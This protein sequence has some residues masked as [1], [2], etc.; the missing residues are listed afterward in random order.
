MR[1]APVSPARRTAC[2]L[3]ADVESTKVPPTRASRTASMPLTGDVRIAPLAP[4]RAPASL[5][6]MA[7]SRQRR[8]AAGAAHSRLLRRSAADRCCRLGLAFHSPQ[9][10]G[11]RCRSSD[12]SPP[13]PL[14]R[15]SATGR[16]L[17]RNAATPRRLRADHVRGQSRRTL[18]SSSHA[19]RRSGPSSACLASRAAAQPQAPAARTRRRVCPSRGGAAPSGLRWARVPAYGPSAPTHS[20]LPVRAHGCGCV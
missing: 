10:R 17:D 4:S 13:P 16:D 3:H 15:C 8:V 2:G 9:S 11:Q 19:R 1:F 7:R 14:G 18:C 12:E 20:H 6:A 5:G